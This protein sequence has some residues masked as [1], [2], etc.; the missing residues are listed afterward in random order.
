[1]YTGDQDTFA[2]PTDVNVIKQVVPTVEEL[3]LLPGHNHNSITDISSPT[4]YTDLF[5]KLDLYNGDRV[6]PLT[7]PK[8]IEIEITLPPAHHCVDTPGWTSGIVN[9]GC[10]VYAQKY[11]QNGQPRQG[12][13]YSLGYEYN[14]PE[15]NCCACNNNYDHTIPIP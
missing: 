13:E 15:Q 14:W 4:F 11:C 5:Q 7:Q 2:T 10:D 8:Q 3:I 12:M 9:E 6:I 1:M